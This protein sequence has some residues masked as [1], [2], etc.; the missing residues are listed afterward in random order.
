MQGWYHLVLAKPVLFI[1]MFAAL[2]ASLGAFF[3]VQQLA[4][5]LNLSKRDRE[6]LIL[7]WANVIAGR[8]LH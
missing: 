6:P 4:A 3:L 2:V 8:G 7:E 1:M 5:R